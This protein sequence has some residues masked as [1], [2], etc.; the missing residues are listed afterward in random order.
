MN[1]RVRGLVYL[2]VAVLVFG[3]SGAVVRLLADLGSEHQAYGA[4][5]ISFCNLL[6]AG[7]AVAAILLFSVSR[8]DWR[9]ERREGLK[10]RDWVSLVVLA[11]LTGAIAPWLMFGALQRTMVT[12]V[13]LVSQIEPP[14]TLLLCS[15]LLGESVTRLS[16]IGA[17]LTVLGVGVW[18]LLSPAMGGYEF[19]EGER[20]ALIAAGIYAVSTLIAR[21][22]L[23]RVPVGLFATIR[24]G[25]GAVFFFFAAIWLY[26]PEHFIGLTVPFVWPWV[27]FYALVIVA[28]GQLAWVA[29]LKTGRTIDVAMATSASPVIGVLAA[30]VLLGEVPGGAQLV[31]GAIVLL[32]IGL[33]LWGAR[34]RAEAIPEVAANIVDEPAELLEAEGR[35]GFKGV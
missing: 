35:A 19:G 34:R 11:L 28:V 3:A 4:P 16:M 2:W 25:L 20:L 26:G 1:A 10:R 9:P 29:G 18:V 32:G 33:G 5:A 17:V 12:N 24:T 8:R 6:F 15:W 31:G 7:N 21:P 27:L 30:Y 14:V 23:E 22:A 13:V